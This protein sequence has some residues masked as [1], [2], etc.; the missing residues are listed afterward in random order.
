VSQNPK[1]IQISRGSKTPLTHVPLLMAY[2]NGEPLVQYTSQFA[3]P[4][5]I[6]FVQKCHAVI[7]DKVDVFGAVKEQEIPQYTTG[8]P[9]CDDDVCYISFDDAYKN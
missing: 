5:M 2:F 4:N 8:I 7:K 3:Q 1:V 6:Q 9:Y